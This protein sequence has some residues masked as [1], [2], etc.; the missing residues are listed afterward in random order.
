M[1][2]K[3][4]Y[5][6]CPDDVQ[7]GGVYARTRKLGFETYLDCYEMVEDDYSL[8]EFRTDIPSQLSLGASYDVMPDFL[9]VEASFVLFLSWHGQVRNRSKPRTPIYGQDKGELYNDGW[10]IGLSTEFIVDD[11][12]IS[13]GGLYA[14]NGA[15]EESLT[16]LFWGNDS[17]SAGTGVTWNVNEAMTATLGVL[18]THYFP[19]TSG[20]LLA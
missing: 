4:D 18:Y 11:F 7:V 1:N 5:A 8:G 6:D 20:L 12:I 16:Y 15:T 14:K 13:A 17:V 10:E 3:R 19:I 2:F 9:R